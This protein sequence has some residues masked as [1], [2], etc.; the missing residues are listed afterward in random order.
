MTCWILRGES[1]GIVWDVR[2][3]R[4]FSSAEKDLQHLEDYCAEHSLDGPF[5]AA[6]SVFFGLLELDEKAQRAFQLEIYSSQVEDR[7]YYEHRTVGI[8]YQLHPLQLI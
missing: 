4:T 7:R 3:Y 8:K 2:A 5:P 1:G 6:P